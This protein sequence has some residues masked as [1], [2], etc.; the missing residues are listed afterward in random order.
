MPRK[1]VTDKLII[2][3]VMHRNTAPSVWVKDKFFVKA[4]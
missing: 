3:M 2:S 4:M 1:L